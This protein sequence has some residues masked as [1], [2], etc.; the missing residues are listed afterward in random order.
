MVMHDGPVIR[1]PTFYNDGTNH[2][3]RVG[4]PLDLGGENITE[5][6][7]L[8]LI[9]QANADAD[10]AGRGQIWVNTA[11]PNELYFTDDAGTD[12]NIGTASVSQANQAA[13]EAETNEDT[14]APPDLVK[15]SPGVAKVWVF[16]EQS[17]AHGITVSYNMTSVTDGGAAGETDHLWNVDFSGADYSIVGMAETN[18]TVAHQESSRLAGGITTRTMTIIDATVTDAKTCIA[19]FGDQ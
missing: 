12:F 5:L 9:E 15:H 17:G 14:Y 11:T 3:L 1:A 4:Q 7:V 2:V 6:G 18:G 13:L 8:L 10:V 19:V 16:W